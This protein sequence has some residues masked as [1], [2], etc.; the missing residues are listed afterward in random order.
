MSRFSRVCRACSAAGA[1]VLG[2]AVS[3]FADLSTFTVPSLDTTVVESAGEKAF[4]IA[5]IVL[6]IT[7]GLRIFK[8]A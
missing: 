2:G 3:A 6:A 5:A 4:A 7:I 1:A 8:R